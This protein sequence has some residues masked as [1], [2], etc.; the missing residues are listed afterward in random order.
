MRTAIFV[1]QTTPI[2]IWTNESDLQLCAMNA[3]TMPLSAG[4]SA[5][6][7]APG[8]YKIVSSQEVKIDGDYSA[9]DIVISPSDKTN[10]P[11]VPPLRAAQTFT[12]LDTAALQD[13]MVTPEAKAVLNP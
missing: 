2:C 10:D 1:Y 11:S 8:I 3:G 5:Q 13:F 6:T 9:L 7:L 4:S 12:S